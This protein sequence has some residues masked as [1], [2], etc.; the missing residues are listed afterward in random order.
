MDV[1]GFLD[2]GADGGEQQQ[3]DLARC[4]GFSL[5]RARRLGKRG[6]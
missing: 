6:R 4:E 1:D 2:I 5:R 3:V